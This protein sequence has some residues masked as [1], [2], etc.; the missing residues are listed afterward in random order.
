MVLKWNP[1]AEAPRNRFLS[2]KIQEKVTLESD[3]LHTSVC[4]PSCM[5]GV[6]KEDHSLTTYNIK[7]KYRCAI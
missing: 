6:L 1:T 7:V 2:S 3:N 5:V 4:L